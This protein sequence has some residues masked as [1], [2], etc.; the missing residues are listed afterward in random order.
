M[1][2]FTSLT[3]QPL[4]AIVLKKVVK[5]RY[6]VNGTIELNFSVEVEADSE[7]EAETYAKMYAEDGVGL[8]FPVD[9]AEVFSIKEIGESAQ[10]RTTK[11]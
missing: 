11:S 9:E 5:V 1:I 2:Q 4:Y 7:Q 3:F 10:N 8:G 6:K